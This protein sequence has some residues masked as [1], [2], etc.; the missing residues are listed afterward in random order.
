M[1]NTIKTP[2]TDL[3]TAITD[4]AQELALST[5]STAEMSRY[6]TRAALRLRSKVDFPE[7]RLASS[8]SFT[9]SSTLPYATVAAPTAW[10]GKPIYLNNA[11]QDY[12][13]HYMHPDALRQL[14]SDSYGY[15]FVEHA[16]AID[17]ANLVIY[18]STTETLT[19]NHYSKYLVATVTTETPK[20]TFNT[21]GTT[22][23]FFI[24]DAEE[25][26]ILQTLLILANK[27]PDS[28]TKYAEL[29]LEFAEALDEY[30]KN[31]PSQ[32]L[33]VIE[34]GDYIG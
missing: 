17:G 1:A 19:L 12:T 33:E 7:T 6:L 21:D 23:D 24:P 25:L 9:A 18:H 32:A 11:D 29:R 34:R 3:R 28:A 14:V 13:F 15:E 8:L 22:G 30:K 31:N 27:E 20:E 26:L 16:F 5:F 10:N 4:R 2:Q